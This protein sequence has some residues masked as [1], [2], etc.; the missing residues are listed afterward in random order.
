M[1]TLW[2]MYDGEPFMENP[3]LGLLLNARR[4]G[5]KGMAK[6]KRAMP[7]G[8]RRYWA[9]HR[10]KNVG[11]KRSPARRRRT[12]RNFPVAGLVTAT[13]PRR[14]HRRLMRNPRRHLRRRRNPVLMGINFP[15]IKEVAFGT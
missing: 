15:P 13:N 11:R 3:H 6:R 12:R 14:R 7:A 4:K 10:R 5:K 8:L 1:R 2:G 9:K